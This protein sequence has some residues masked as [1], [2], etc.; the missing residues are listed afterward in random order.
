MSKLVLTKELYE[1]SQVLCIVVSLSQNS[2]RP[3]PGFSLSTTAAAETVCSRRIIE[4]HHH[5]DAGL[6]QGRL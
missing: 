1:M 3:R 4:T 2:V 6:R 5:P